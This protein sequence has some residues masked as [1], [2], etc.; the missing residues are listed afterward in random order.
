MSEQ[1]TKQY[2]LKKLFESS[3]KSL[4]LIPILDKPNREQKQW[5][6]RKLRHVFQ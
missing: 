2:H 6:K 5:I 4:G 1:E 3:R